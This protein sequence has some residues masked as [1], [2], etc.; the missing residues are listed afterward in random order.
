ML[1]EWQEGHPPVKKLSDEVLAWL[2]VLGKV[3]VC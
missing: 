1:V 3:Q 2:S